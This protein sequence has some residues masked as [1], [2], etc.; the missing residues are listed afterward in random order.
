MSTAFDLQPIFYS[1]VDYTATLFTEETGVWRRHT[2]V[3]I[4]TLPCAAYCASIFLSASLLHC[5]CLWY[6]AEAL[7]PLEGAAVCSAMVQHYIQSRQAHCC[8]RCSAGGQGSIPLLV[9]LSSSFYRSFFPLF[10][11]LRWLYYPFH[12]YLGLAKSLDS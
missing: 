1:A 2:L 11:P 7:M 4:S 6:F 9:V 8:C 10:L 3:Q 12:F 5:A